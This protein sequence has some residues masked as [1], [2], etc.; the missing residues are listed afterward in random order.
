MEV[1]VMGSTSK[2]SM[3]E[4]MKMSSFWIFSNNDAKKKSLA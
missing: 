3:R 1:F 4:S 2:R